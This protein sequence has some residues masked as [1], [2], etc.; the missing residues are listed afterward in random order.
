MNLPKYTRM[1]DMHT[2]NTWTANNLRSNYSLI[3]ITRRNKI[4]LQL[5]NLVKKCFINVNIDLLSKF[6]CKH[7]IKSSL[8]R[9]LF[10]FHTGV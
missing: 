7:L 2:Y 6:K 4:D 8:L 5:Y 3:E 9:L 10:L 1:S